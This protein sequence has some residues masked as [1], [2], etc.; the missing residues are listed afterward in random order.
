[1]KLGTLAC[2]LSS[3]LILVSSFAAEPRPNI[4]VILCDNLGTPDT[5]IIGGKFIKS[6]RDHHDDPEEMTRG[7][8]VSVNA[9]NF[10][11]C[12]PV[13]IPVALWL[14]V[15]EHFHLATFL[16]VLVGFV[17]VTNEAHKWTHMPTVPRWLQWLQRHHV[18]LRPE[19]HRLHH[20]APYDSN[21]CI[22]SGVLNP[23][24]ERV[25]FWPRLLRLLR[26]PT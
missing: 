26:R 6:F 14:D 8:F 3:F 25:G 19:N 10:F 15:G 2:L 16:L 21:Y 24:L 9:D 13:V 5:P 7:D 1:M 17:I 4:V 20:T 23:V 18:I 12:L 22:T 11:V